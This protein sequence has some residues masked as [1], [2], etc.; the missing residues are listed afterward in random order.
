MG[1]Q[2]TGRIHALRFVSIKTKQVKEK[3]FFFSVCQ[4]KTNGYIVLPLKRQMKL[5]EVK[6]S[7]SLEEKTKETC[8]Q[9]HDDSI[10]KYQGGQIRK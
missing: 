5:M 2:V 4:L 9:S 3:L 10:Y 1:G 7:V 6:E 8:D